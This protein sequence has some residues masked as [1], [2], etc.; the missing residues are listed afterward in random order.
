MSIISDALRKA[1]EKRSNGS[2]ITPEPELL[3]AQTS[4]EKKDIER[5]TRKTPSTRTI[6]AIVAGVIFA[7]VTP[8]IILAMHIRPS[9]TPA[10]TAAEK[11]VKKKTPSPV[12]AQEVSVVETKKTPPKEIPQEV[13]PPV[14]EET[15][16]LPSLSGIMYSPTYP[17][18]IL[19]G[20]M[21]G[22]GSKVDGFVIK[23]ILTDR[24]KL[25]RNDKEYVIKLR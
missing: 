6:I 3:A 2:S 25:I 15:V 10:K 8:L 22:E 5:L 16:E 23:K 14:F 24:I 13:K 7:V 19:N 9:S 11:T 20:E 18:A 17:M 4:P 12:K 1:Q 21:L